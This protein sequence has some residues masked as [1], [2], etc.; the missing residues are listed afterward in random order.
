M[1]VL[2]ENKCIN[3]CTVP[4]GREWEGWRVRSGGRGGGGGLRGRGKSVLL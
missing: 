2:R 1:G 4:L 3:A